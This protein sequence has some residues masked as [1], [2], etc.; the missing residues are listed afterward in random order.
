MRF[1]SIAC[2]AAVVELVKNFKISVNSRTC[3]KLEM[4]PNEFL[5][6]KKG[7]LWLD[8]RPVQMFKICS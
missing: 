3:E 7:G 5:N 2:K 6:I 8:F 1:A 4:D